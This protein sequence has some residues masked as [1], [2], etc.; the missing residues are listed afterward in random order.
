MSQLYFFEL[1]RLCRNVANIKWMEFLFVL[2]EHE[3]ET[4]EARRQV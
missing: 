1:R 2:N 4:A 3:M